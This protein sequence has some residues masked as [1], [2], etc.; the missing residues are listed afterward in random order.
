MTRSGVRTPATLCRIRAPISHCTR[1]C[2]K[3][4]NGRVSE[5]PGR[6]ENQSQ[7]ER[8]AIS[9]GKANAASDVGG[10]S[11]PPRSHHPDVDPL[12]LPA[13]ARGTIAASFARGVSTLQVMRDITLASSL[14][15]SLEVAATAATLK[16]GGYQSVAPITL[17]QRRRAQAKPQKSSLVTLPI[18]QTHNQ[19]RIS[20]SRRSCRRRCERR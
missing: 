9:S 6:K 7:V 14:P 11:H 2:T 10:S 5:G 1:L 20:R 17:Q 8:V 3:Y 18:S 15:N 19:S 12:P 16:R 4:N 13:I